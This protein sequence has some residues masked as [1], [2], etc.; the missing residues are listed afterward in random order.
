MMAALLGVG[1][2]LLGSY[3]KRQ[4]KQAGG[5]VSGSGLATTGVI[6][7]I[8]ASSLAALTALISLASI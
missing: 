8:V 2:L 1:S 3:A 7:G 5:G 6:L 4:I